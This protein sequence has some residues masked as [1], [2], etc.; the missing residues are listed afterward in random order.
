MNDKQTY[1]NCKYFS[2][3]NRCPHRDNELMKQFILETEV[4]QS[5]VPINLNF[6]KEVEVNKICSSCDKF[7]PHQS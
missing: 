5:S 7:K 4:P 2:I 3:R 6:S 1:H